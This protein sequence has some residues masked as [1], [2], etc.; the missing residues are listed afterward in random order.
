MFLLAGIGFHL[1]W[2]NIGDTIVQQLRP[3]VQPRI[4]A[5]T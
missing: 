2:N 1:L 3:A 5:Q 4:E